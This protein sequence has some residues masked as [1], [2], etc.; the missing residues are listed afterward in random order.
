MHFG[1]RRSLSPTLIDL[2]TGAKNS[3]LRLG[4]TTQT[5]GD[6]ARGFLGAV[7]FVGVY[8]GQGGSPAPSLTGSIAALPVFPLLEEAAAL[9]VRGQLE[10]EGAER[11]ASVLTFDTN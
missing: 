1:G 11:K 9:Q 10:C 7:A 6:G 5:W 2:G 4:E 8:M 3:V